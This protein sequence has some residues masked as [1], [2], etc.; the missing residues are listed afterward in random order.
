LLI[1]YR[2][3]SP[4]HIVVHL[5]FPVAGPHLTFWGFFVAPFPEMSSS[6][7]LFNRQRNVHQILGGGLGK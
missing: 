2:G 1:H 7:R 5:I 4:D 6:D 3:I